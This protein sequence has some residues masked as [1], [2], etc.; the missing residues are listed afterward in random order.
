MTGDQSQRRVAGSLIGSVVGDALGAPFEFGPPMAFSRRF[1]SPAR[2]VATEMCGN[3]MWEPGEWTD[4]TQMALLVAASLIEHNGL[5]EPDL[6]DRFRRWAAADP[7]DVGIQTSAVLRSDRPW[8][9]AAA[10]HF[11]SGARAAGNGSLM[12]TT[13]AAIWF[14][15]FGREATMEAARRISALTHGDPA[16]GEGCAIFHE[17]VRVALAGDDLLSAVEPALSLVAEE[18]R[19]RWAAVLDPTWTPDRATEANGAVWPTLGS[20][21]WALRV[22]TSFEDA[23]RRVIDLGGDTDTVAAVTGGLAGA[24]FGIAGIPMRWT[25][26]VHG[27]L[28]GFPTPVTHLGQ[29]HELAAALDG[30]PGPSYIRTHGSGVGPTE[31]ADGL[32]AADLNGAADS[33]RDFA[34]VSLCRTGGRFGHAV[35]RW[36]YLVDD[37]SN[38]ELREVLDDVLDDVV[39]LQADGRQV[40]VHCFAGA[41]RT[42]LVLRSWLMRERGMT[43]DE[44]TAYVGQRWPH[45]GVWNDSFATILEKVSRHR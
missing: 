38:L 19:D 3:R 26:A 16:A 13:P 24:V 18:H 17:L 11:A 25:S 33:E 12:R 9:V 44:A 21:V 6:F 7:K 5:D 37:E 1:P 23:M 32:W 4:D 36:A 39:A 20:A 22:S 40:L 30:V 14:A 8:N 29:L 42:G 2:G 43:V 35:H 41:S 27:T 28:P 10:E 45:L 15:R 34:V 31:I